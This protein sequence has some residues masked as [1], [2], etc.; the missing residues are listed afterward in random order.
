MDVMSVFVVPF[1]TNVVLTG[2]GEPGDGRRHVHAPV[3]GGEA[4]TY[5]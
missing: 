3:E 1:V 2:A 4:C 5:K